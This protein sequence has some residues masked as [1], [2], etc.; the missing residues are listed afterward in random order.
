[1]V[2]TRDKFSLFGPPGNG[3]FQ[4]RSQDEFGL[5]T[6]V[7]LTNVAQELKEPDVPRQVAFTHAAE[8]AQ[9]RLEQRK[10]TL[11]PILMHLPACVF[12]PRMIHGS[13]FRCALWSCRPS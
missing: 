8:H 6:G 3:G 2:E 9:I 7:V 12:F 4:R 10:E 1:V 13:C 11:H 5:L